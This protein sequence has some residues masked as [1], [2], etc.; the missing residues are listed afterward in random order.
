MGADWVN[1][2]PSLSPEL[3]L[4]FIGLGHAISGRNGSIAALELNSGKKI[5]EFA[6][7]GA[8]HGTPN[9][10]HQLRLLACGTDDGELLLFDP[11]TCTLRWRFA[12]GG[13]IR[14]APIFDMERNTIV[15]GVFDGSI[16]SVIIQSGMP[17]WSVRTG[18]AIY[19]TPLLI[20]NRVYVTSTDKR[21]YVLNAD[22]GKI[23]CRRLTHGRIY[24][25]PRLIEGQIYFGSTSGTVYEF[26]PSTNAITG[27]VQLPERI[28]NAIAYSVP[29]GLFYARSYDGQ[30]Y[31]FRRVN[32][33]APDDCSP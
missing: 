2:S 23:V 21:F 9:Y 28:T 14:A 22:D 26:D 30:I 15:F 31:A 16:Q 11:T 6:V 10:S 25:S 7:K 8:V 29:A 1:S 33:G 18:D 32:V 4:L 5:W 19:S 17:V 13:K 27:Q 12:C 20:K 3:G 24:S